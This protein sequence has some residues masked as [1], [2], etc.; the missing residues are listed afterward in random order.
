MAAHW[1]AVEAGHGQYSPE[2]FKYLDSHVFSPPKA[3][4]DGR[5]TI[6]EDEQ[7]PRSTAVPSAPP[8]REVASSATGKP[9]STRVTLTAEERDIARSTRSKYQTNEEAELAYAR[10]KMKYAEAKKSGQYQERG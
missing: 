3:T 9:Q 6:V 1:D 5:L 2:Y 4:E 10:S 8:T 7:K